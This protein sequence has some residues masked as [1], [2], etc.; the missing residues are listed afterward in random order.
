MIGELAACEAGET[1][2]TL[3]DNAPLSAAVLRLQGDVYATWARV[4]GLG[5]EAATEAMAR[6]WNTLADLSGHRVL[7]S[8]GKSA[9]QG[10]ALS[11][12]LRQAGDVRQAAWTAAAQDGADILH[13]G[14]RTRV[15]HAVSEALGHLQVAA[16]SLRKG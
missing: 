5:S 4:L 10:V 3:L 1:T 16:E 7:L 12:L 11:A 8:S 13:T 6:A 15:A 2:A 9:T 14:P